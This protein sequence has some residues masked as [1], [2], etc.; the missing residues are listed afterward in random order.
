MFV[1]CVCVCVCVLLFVISFAFVLAFMR[2]WFCFGLWLHFL[3]V[4]VIPFA[5]PF[6]FGLVACACDSVYAG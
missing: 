6:V 2:L 5:L 1:F 3:R 4:F